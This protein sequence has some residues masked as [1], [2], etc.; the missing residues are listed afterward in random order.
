MRDMISGHPQNLSQQPI[1]PETCVREAILDQ[2][3]STNMPADPRYMSEPSQDQPSLATVSRTSQLTLDLG[4]I[5][6]DQW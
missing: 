3:A 5:I 1:K 2:P 4:A 6:H